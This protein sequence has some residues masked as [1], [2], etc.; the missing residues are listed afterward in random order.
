M[1]GYVN[2]KDIRHTL[3]GEE[4][5]AQSRYYMILSRI[6]NSHLPKNYAYKDVKMLVTKKDFVNWFMPRDFYRCS[7]DRIDPKKDYTLDN[8]QVISL[9]DN[10]RKD[11]LISDGVLSTCSKCKEIKPLE[12]FCKDS[13]ISI[14]YNTLCL[15]CER[16]R[17]REK[18]RKRRQVAKLKKLN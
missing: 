10:I 17:S 2:G 16:L 7:V 4:H 13:R 1:S 5:R 11:K 12:L 18:A 3:I 6:K 9:T 8:M 14:G 15:D